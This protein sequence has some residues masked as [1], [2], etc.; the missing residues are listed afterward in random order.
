MGIKGLYL[1]QHLTSALH[2]GVIYKE[3]SSVMTHQVTS[4]LHKLLAFGSQH[5]QSVC[6]MV[7]LMHLYVI[8][9]SYKCSHIK[10]LKITPTC[11]DHQLII[12]RELI[13]S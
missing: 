9:H 10:T 2:W 5:D 1:Y 8:K 13:R 6:V 3:A 7:Q 12:V 4:L 11:F